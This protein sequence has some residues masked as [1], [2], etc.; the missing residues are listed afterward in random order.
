VNTDGTPEGFFELI[1]LGSLGHWF[2]GQGAEF[3]RLTDPPIICTRERLNRFLANKDNFRGH[4]DSALATRMEKAKPIE[5]ELKVSL[6]NDDAT[7]QLLL[8]RPHKGFVRQT[9]TLKRKFPHVEIR[10]EDE[11]K[12]VLELYGDVME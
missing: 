10:L 5:P 3:S 11:E 6:D 7:V 2:Y 8:F 12:C 9:R 1:V 4:D